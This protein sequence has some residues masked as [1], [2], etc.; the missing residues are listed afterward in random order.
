MKQKA[1]R[2]LVVMLTVMIIFGYLA[3]LVADE[4]N[5]ATADLDLCDLGCELEH[6]DG[7]HC[8][9]GHYDEENCDWGHCDEEICDGVICDGDN[10][11][12]DCYSEHCGDCECENG[13]CDEQCDVISSEEV[14]SSSSVGRRAK[15]EAVCN[16]VWKT[17]VSKQPGCTTAGVYVTRCTKCGAYAQNGNGYITPLGHKWSGRNV[18]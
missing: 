9:G 3:P 14:S 2:I 6:C 11:D 15:A 8:D 7:D 10:C 12:G 17:E 5:A 16:H 18:S 1:K 4:A 13:H